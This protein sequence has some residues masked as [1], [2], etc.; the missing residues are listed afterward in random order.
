MCTA[1][2]NKC[3]NQWLAQPLTLHNEKTKINRR[4]GIDEEDEEDEQ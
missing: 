3:S 2:H 1:L 4:P